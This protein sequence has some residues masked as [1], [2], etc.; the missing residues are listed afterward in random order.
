M[1]TDRFLQAEREVPAG[2]ATAVA[3]AEV[4]EAVDKV[5]APG[6]QSRIRVRTSRRKIPEIRAVP[7]QKKTIQRKRIQS[8]KNQRRKG[9]RI[10]RQ[11]VS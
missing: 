6:E 8:R 11:P 2:V 5:A 9:R 10:A 3:G 1:R 4:L 7:L